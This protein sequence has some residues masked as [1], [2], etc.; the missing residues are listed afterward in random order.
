MYKTFIL[1]LN[2]YKLLKLFLNHMT[3]PSINQIL[4]LS[5]YDIAEVSKYCNS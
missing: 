5:S 2:L 3:G 4:N 1:I